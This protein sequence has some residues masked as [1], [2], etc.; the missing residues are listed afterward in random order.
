MKNVVGIIRAKASRINQSKLMPTWPPCTCYGVT[1]VHGSS[2]QPTKCRSASNSVV[3]I[4]WNNQL[5]LLDKSWVGFGTVWPEDGKKQPYFSISCT[6][7][8]KS[9]FLKS[10]AL[11]IVQNVLATLVRKFVQEVLSKI[12]QSCHTDS[13][14]IRNSWA[15]FSAFV[16]MVGDCFCSFIGGY[17]IEMFLFATFLDKP[18]W[19]SVQND[20]FTSLA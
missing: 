19:T 6:K 2:P 4:T 18:K 15:C 9:F 17:Q 3:T 8:R 14:A 12:A 5:S 13:G 7:R 1:N 10:D 11:T 16:K 20:L